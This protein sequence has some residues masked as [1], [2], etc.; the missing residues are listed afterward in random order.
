MP[1]M[2]FPFCFKKR[3]TW[4]KWYHLFD[5]FLGKIEYKKNRFIDEET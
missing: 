5:I 4:T 1:L 3:V 2:I